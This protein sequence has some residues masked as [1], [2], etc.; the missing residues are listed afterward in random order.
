[1]SNYTP[2]EWTF[3]GE[4][5]EFWIVDENGRQLAAVPYRDTGDGLEPLET[6]DGAN[7]RLM[8]AAPALLAALQEAVAAFPQSFDGN[9]E[10][11][12]GGDLLEWFSEWR[13]KAKAAVAIAAGRPPHA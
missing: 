2:G 8:A 7:A 10:E 11:L 12:N 1:M 5:D 9:E 4:G 13:E 6:E 3:E